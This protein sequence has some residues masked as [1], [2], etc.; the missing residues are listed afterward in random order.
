M[1]SCLYEG[2]VQH[3]RFDPIEHSFRYRLFLVFVD[4]AELDSLFGRRGVWSTRWPALARFRRADYLGD[5]VRPLD[6]CVRDLVEQRTGHRPSGPVGVLTNFRYFGFGMNPVS[7]Y[8]C[9]DTAGER[10]ETVV[11]EVSNTPWNERHCYVLSFAVSDAAAMHLHDEQTGTE[12]QSTGR[13]ENPKEFHVSP[14]MPMDMTYR[15]RVTE[16][17]ERLAVTIEN[18]SNDTKRFDATLSLQRRPIT[19]WQLARALLR[20]PLMTMQIFLGIYWQALRLWLK[21]VPYVPH[22]RVAVPMPT[23]SGPQLSSSK[24]TTL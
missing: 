5:P 7:F 9:F 3:R 13:F 14:F 20:Y 22:P 4:L 21:R 23:A 19:R 8:Y 2:V 6:D 10:V 15:W 11:A 16:P 12:S 24:Q 17:R 1:R 18:Y